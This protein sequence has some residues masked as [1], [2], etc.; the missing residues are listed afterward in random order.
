M[1]IILPENR[2]CMHDVEATIQHRFD[3]ATTEVQCWNCRKQVRVPLMVREADIAEVRAFIGM[4]RNFTAKHPE[5][6]QSLLQ[7]V[8]DTIIDSRNKPPI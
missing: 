6:T 3:T 4:L 8:V 5:I 1:A 7:D 2:L